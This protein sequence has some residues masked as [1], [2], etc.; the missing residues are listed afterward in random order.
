MINPA[1]RKQIE[2][3]RVLIPATVAP[4]RDCKICNGKGFMRRV[5]NDKTVEQVCQ[6]VVVFKPE[7]IPNGPNNS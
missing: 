3:T 4:L 7:E 1:H 6:C 5:L 2:K